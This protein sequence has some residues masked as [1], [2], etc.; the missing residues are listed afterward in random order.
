MKKMNYYRTIYALN[1]ILIYIDITASAD[2]LLLNMI[3]RL[4]N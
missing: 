4:Q 1:R 2:F 3:L